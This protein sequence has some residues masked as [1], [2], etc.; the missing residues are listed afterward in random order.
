MHT[1]VYYYVH[2]SWQIVSQEENESGSSEIEVATKNKMM[3]ILHEAAERII[4]MNTVYK[5]VSLQ[6]QSDVLQV[7][8]MC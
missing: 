7:V 5:K 2:T 8:P 1:T 6:L 3:D 4:I